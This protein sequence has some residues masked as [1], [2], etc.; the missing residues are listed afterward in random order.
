MG[1]S[2]SSSI[3]RLQLQLVNF[4]LTNLKLLYAHAASR[5]IQ[6][7]N[8]HVSGPIHRQN[9]YSACMRE[10]LH[11][12]TLPRTWL[13]IL[14]SWPHKYIARTTAWRE[15]QKGFLELWTLVQAPG[16]T[17]LHHKYKRSPSY[18]TCVNPLHYLVFEESHRF[19]RLLVVWWFGGWCVSSSF[20]CLDMNFIYESE[21]TCINTIC[22]AACL[23][24]NLCLAASASWNQT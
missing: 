16:T 10:G 21:L 18:I 20:G 15:S 3:N 9:G 19:T 5:N 7:P 12:A 17:Q 14:R 8:M 6:E 1:R 4:L 13:P 11:E 2:S 23:I 24:S 22:K